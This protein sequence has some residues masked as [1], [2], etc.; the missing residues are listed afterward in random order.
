MNSGKIVTFSIKRTRLADCCAT[1]S[2]RTQCPVT[3]LRS[4][5][6][7]KKCVA[8]SKPNNLLVILDLEKLGELPKDMPKRLDAEKR[9]MVEISPN[10]EGFGNV[11]NFQV[12]NSEKFLICAFSNNKVGVFDLLD[13]SL[14]LEVDDLDQC[15]SCHIDE[16]GAFMAMLDVNRKQVNIYS[17]EWQ[18]EVEQPIRPKRML[19]NVNEE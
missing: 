1:L 13:G 8:F 16:A 17:L 18:W 7:N 14:L 6:N 3:Q 9:H 15:Q 12:D 4:F 19:G 10:A 2:W 5:M 11:E